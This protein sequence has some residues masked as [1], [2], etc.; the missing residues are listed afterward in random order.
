MWVTHRAEIELSRSAFFLLRLQC[1]SAGP[2]RKVEIE[3]ANAYSVWCAWNAAN[4]LPRVVLR[5]MWFSSCARR[6]RSSAPAEDTNPS[7]CP[8]GPWTSSFM[9]FSSLIA[10]AHTPP[11]SSTPTFS[12]EFLCDVTFF[13]SPD[14]SAVLCS[15]DV[16]AAS[17][18]EREFSDSSD[19][20]HI[21]NSPLLLL[22]TT[23]PGTYLFISGGSGKTHTSTVGL[24]PRPPAVISFR[25]LISLGPEFLSTSMSVVI[26]A[27][28]P[29]PREWNFVVFDGKQL[30]S[31][32]IYALWW[33]IAFDRK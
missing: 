7:V 22:R 20:E 3:M 2:Y 21:M 33:K 23:L 30:I 28:Q 19:L 6:V 24:S 15:Q 27:K 4:S 5:K 1:V 11:L 18:W 14:D 16:R 13:H 17:C 29:N 10:R 32:I 26:K 9:G 12:T 31:Y 8:I 25:F